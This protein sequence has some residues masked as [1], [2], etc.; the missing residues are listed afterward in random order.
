MPRSAQKHIG[1]FFA[2]TGILLL[3][4]LVFIKNGVDERDVFLCDAIAK[5]G[6]DM[7]EC[8]AHDSYTSWFLVG[9]FIVGF[10]LFAIGAYWSIMPVKKEPVEKKEELAY[11]QVDRETLTEEERKIYDLLRIKDG[12]MYQSELIQETGFSKVQMTRILDRMEGRKIIE[13]K[14]RGMTNV[15]ILH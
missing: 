15:I 13:R 8:P 3:T 12:S 4:F 7:N 1:I 9:A 2:I 11:N 5:A 14:R 6:M 10:M